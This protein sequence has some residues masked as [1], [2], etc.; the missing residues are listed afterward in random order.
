MIVG[1]SDRATFGELRARG[2]TLR[3]RNLRIR[4]LADPRATTLAVAYAIPRRVGGAVQRNR[5]RRR[6]RGALEECAGAG[7]RFPPGAM[8]VIVHRG[9]A[10]ITYTELR[11]ELVDL[12]GRLAATHSPRPISP[13]G[14]PD[15]MVT[16]DM[17][18][19][20]T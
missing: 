18:G 9:A 1:I 14:E 2:V 11:A 16:I 5:I 15:A 17:T 10:D 8:M 19:E 7:H 4:H 12:M 20:G 6:I 13:A 3:S